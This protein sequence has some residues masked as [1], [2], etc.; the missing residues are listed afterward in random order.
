MAT[1]TKAQQSAAALAYRQARADHI[2][3]VLDAEIAA[4][5]ERVQ[6]AQRALERH[7]NRY[8]QLIEART[9][10]RELGS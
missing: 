2:A 5:G 4:T 8:A 9:D 10:L 6:S 3:E 1:P 7:R